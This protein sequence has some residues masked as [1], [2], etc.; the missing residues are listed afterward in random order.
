MTRL[1]RLGLR[2]LSF[3]QK[4]L[5]QDFG[6]THFYVRVRSSW[7]IGQVFD[8]VECTFL[9]EMVRNKYIIYYKEQSRTIND[10]C[11]MS[12]IPSKTDIKVTTSPWKD[13]PFL[14]AVG[15]W[16]NARIK[17]SESNKNIWHA[18]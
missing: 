6:V 1:G 8:E 11:K 7:Y 13:Q 17:N 16:N 2:I 4:N 12:I 3:T 5:G 18:L 14:L 9:F 10:A 15:L